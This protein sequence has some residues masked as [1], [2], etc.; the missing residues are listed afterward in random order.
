MCGNRDPKIECIHLSQQGRCTSGIPRLFIYGSE[1]EESTGKNTVTTMVTSFKT[2]EGREE[3]H[4]IVYDE[5]EIGLSDEY[6]AGVGVR[7]R[8]FISNKPE[9]LMG[10]VVITHNKYL[11]NELLDIN[12]NH[13]NMSSDLTL[14][15]IVTRDVVPNSDLENLIEKSHEK[16]MEIVRLLKE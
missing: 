12:P 5:P 3:D 1:D 6:S 8:E 15:E 11:I 16:Y 14:E 13:L 10:A 7:I 9:K 2:S 4:F